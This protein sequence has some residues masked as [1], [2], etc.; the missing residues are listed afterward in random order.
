MILNTAFGNTGTA[1]APFDLG[2]TTT[3]EVGHW[4]NL[5]HIW[6]DDGTGCQGSDLVRRHAEPGERELRQADV[7]EH[8]VQATARTATC[9]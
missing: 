6:G 4:L 9:S 8:L 7:P 3:H 5:F 2:R 1:T